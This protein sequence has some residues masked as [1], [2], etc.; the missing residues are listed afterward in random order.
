MGN[1]YTNVTVRG[2]DKANVVV[3]VKTLGYR[4]F[5]A[6]T[7]ADLT[8]ICEEQSDTQ[9]RASWLEVAKQLSQKLNCPALAVMN[10]DDDILSYA[11]YRKGRLLD[12]YNSCPDYW[13]NADAPFPPRGGDAQ[14]LCEAFGMPGNAVEVER[15][16]RAMP[17]SDDEDADTEE[18]FVF[19][20]EHHAALVK[21]L[22][23]PEIPYQQGF[24]YLKQDGPPPEWR[25]VS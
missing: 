9:D 17:D 10:H 13:A 12:E 1:F 20:W 14:V 7:V 24:D 8:V 5:V 18:E 19:A 3:A 22:D 16:L 23:W 25:L 11:L 15:V 21:A 2:P 4:A 6:A